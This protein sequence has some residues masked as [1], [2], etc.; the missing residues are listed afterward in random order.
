M[1][2]KE[3]LSFKSLLQKESLNDSL[4]QQCQE[5]LYADDIQELKNHMQFLLQR[6]NFLG[7][8]L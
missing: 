1:K 2:L 3:F 6:K 4:F 5:E 7:E 8:L